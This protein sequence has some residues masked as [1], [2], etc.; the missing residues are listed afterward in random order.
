M[1]TLT[2]DGFF[3]G[4]ISSLTPRDPRVSLRRCFYGRLYFL[5]GGVSLI[6]TQ[7]P[8]VNSTPVSSVTTHTLMQS[9]SPSPVLNHAQ[10]ITWIH[11]GHLTL[12]NFMSELT[13]FPTDLILF[14]YFQASQMV[15]PPV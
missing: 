15:P 7:Y 6:S 11:H 14:C 3:L 13:A 1:D 8:S 5:M 9:T 2:A 12:S 10:D 4:V